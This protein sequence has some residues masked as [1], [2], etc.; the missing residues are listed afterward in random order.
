MSLAC[1]GRIIGDQPG[2]V[3]EVLDVPA[4]WPPSRGICEWDWLGI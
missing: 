2:E 3:L 1:G 4:R